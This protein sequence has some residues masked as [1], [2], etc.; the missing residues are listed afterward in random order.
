[1]RLDH[2]RMM[3]RYNQWMNSRLYQIAASMSEAELKADKGA[4]F[5][6][7]LGTFNHVAVGDTIWLQ[8]FATHPARHSALDPVR[9]L[10]PPASLNQMLYSELEQLVVYRDMLDKLIVL[11]SAELSEADLDHVLHYKNTKGLAF[12]KPF[13]SLVMHFFNHQTHHRGQATTLFSQAG[14]DVGVTDLLALIPDFPQ[15]D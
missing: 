2:V 9:E 1:M 6:S 5:G 4:F 8:R 7:V 3:A 13:F 10:P 11:W 12:N 14:I 15:V